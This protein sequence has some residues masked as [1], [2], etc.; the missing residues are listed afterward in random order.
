MDADLI[1][2]FALA[3][4]SGKINIQVLRKFLKKKNEAAVKKLKQAGE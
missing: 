1:I 4:S 3:G 2:I